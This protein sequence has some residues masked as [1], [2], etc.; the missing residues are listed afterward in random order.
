M[1]AVQTVAGRDLDS[2]KVGDARHFVAAFEHYRPV[3][4]VLCGVRNYDGQTRCARGGV[5][6]D[7]ILLRLS[8]QAEGISVSEI[9][10]F[11]EREGFKILD[12]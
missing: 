3:V 1:P 12:A 2:V 10:F 7:Y 5:N 4:N 6:A 11:R 9:F 8:H